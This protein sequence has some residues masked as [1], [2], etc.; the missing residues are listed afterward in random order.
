MGKS[1]GANRAGGRL[2]G[3][4]GKFGGLE[5]VLSFVRLYRIGNYRLVYKI[6]D[7]Y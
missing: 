3:A 7:T 1:P 4:L 6:D 5:L 2:G